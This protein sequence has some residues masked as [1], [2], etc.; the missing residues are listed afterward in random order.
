MAQ[1]DGLMQMRSFERLEFAPNTTMGFTPGGKH[2]M[3]SGPRAP[4]L[5]G[6]LVPVTLVFDDGRK[7]TVNVPVSPH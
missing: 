6:D 2:L 1:V 7:Q 4:L 3:L 5:N